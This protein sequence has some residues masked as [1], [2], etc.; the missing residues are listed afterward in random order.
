MN[1][2]IRNLAFAAV[3]AFSASAVMASTLVSAGDKIKFANGNG[4]NPGGAF[5]LTNWGQNGA[6]NLGSFESFC[7]EYNEYMNYGGPSYSQGPT[8]KVNS[9]SDAAKNGGAGGRI[10]DPNG[11]TYDPL[12]RKTAYLYTKYIEDQ[13][14]LNGATGW[15]TATLVQKGTAMQQAI[16]YIEQER[17]LGQIG[18]LAL[19]LVNLAATNIL[20]WDEVGT[21]R[22]KALNL[23]WFSGGGTS[24]PT[25]T[26]AQDQLYLAPVPLPAAG[27]L[28]LSALGLGG[29]LK[30]KRREATAAV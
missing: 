8:F 11:G 24:Y 20:S 1:R 16:W 22:V 17:A 23:T 2:T 30:K 18:A 4:D 5:I 10:A 27:W 15:N 28:M 14:A 13:G 19:Q 6:A 21:G 12:D 9:I 26:P 25:G 29:L 3:T 7:L